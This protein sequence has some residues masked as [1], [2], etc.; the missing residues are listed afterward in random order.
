MLLRQ[1]F[2]ED[3]QPIGIDV[4]HPPASPP[5]PTPSR[6]SP[7]RSPPPD[8]SGFESIKLSSQPN[9]SLH[10]WASPAFLKRKAP[11]S[12]PY[13]GSL[14]DPFGD[15]S[16]YPEVSPTKRT[17]FSRKSAEWRFIERTPS[18]PLEFGSPLERQIEQQIEDEV[19][20]ANA[21][22]QEA[23][24]SPVSEPGLPMQERINEPVDRNQASPTLEL[25]PSH[26]GSVVEA[27]IATHSR[28]TLKTPE[29][30][31]ENRLSHDRDAELSPSTTP[32]TQVQEAASELTSNL[33]AHES[34]HDRVQNK[35][36]DVELY[37]RSEDSNPDF[38][39]TTS[40][41]SH[42]GDEALS[43]NIVDDDTVPYLEESLNPSGDKDPQEE[44]H[45]PLFS[46]ADASSMKH[47]DYSE[48]TTPSNQTLDEY[49]R[50]SIIGQDSLSLQTLEGVLRNSNGDPVIES[51]RDDQK[52]NRASPVSVIELSSSS[53]VQANPRFQSPSEGGSSQSE[54]M[55]DLDDY[56]DFDESVHSTNSEEEEADYPSDSMSE[57]EYED[58]SIEYDSGAEH[59]TSQAR[60][61]G[62]VYED[63]YFSKRSQYEEEDVSNPI[64][65]Q[66]LYT[67]SSGSEDNEIAQALPDMQDREEQRSDSQ[68]LD[69][70][71][72][73]IRSATSNSDVV[74]FDKPFEQVWRE[75][76]AGTNEP[77]N[78]PRGKAVSSAR[79][80]ESSRDVS[81]L[82]YETLPLSRP[83]TRLEVTQEFQKIK[84]PSPITESAEEQ[85]AHQEN[86]ANSEKYK[87]REAAF[88]G[89][90]LD[91]RIVDHNDARKSLQRSQPPTQVE[92][93]SPD[94]KSLQQMSPTSAAWA[95]LEQLQGSDTSK[96]S[97]TKSENGLRQLHQ[98]APDILPYAPDLAHEEGS[99]ATNKNLQ[100]PASLGDRPGRQQ[101]AGAN[102]ATSRPVRDSSMQEISLSE[103]LPSTDEAK[104]MG[105]NI[106][107]IEP[108]DADYWDE[109]D[110][111]IEE[112]DRSSLLDEAESD[113]GSDVMDYVE[114][115]DQQEADS[116]QPR[117]VRNKMFP[118]KSSIVEIIDLDTSD[119]EVPTTPKKPVVSQQF[120]EEIDN[121][122][123]GPNHD[124]EPV[125]EDQSDLL[126]SSDSESMNEQDTAGIQTSAEHDEMVGNR[127]YSPVSKTSK[128][129][130]NDT[131]SED[132]SFTE[133][134]TAEPHHS[135]DYEEPTLSQK[136]GSETPRPLTTVMH[137]TGTTP[138][139][140]IEEI[141]EQAV[142]TI[143]QIPESHNDGPMMES[144]NSYDSQY[145]DT[146][147]PIPL[148]E[149]DIELISTQS[150]GNRSKP[151]LDEISDSAAE[152]QPLDKVSEMKSEESFVKMPTS[153]HRDTSLQND[154]AEMEQDEISI[155][156]GNDSNEDY[157]QEYTLE[158]SRD[159]LEQRTQLPTPTA[160]QLTRTK[161]ESSESLLT[162]EAEN[163]TLPTPSLTQRTSEV[164]HTVVTQD[165]ELTPKIRSE[166]FSHDE[167][168]DSPDVSNVAPTAYP[169][170][171]PT[172]PGSLRKSSLVQRLKEMR[173]ESAK[174]HRFSP[175]NDTSS[176]ASPWFGPRRSS[177]LAEPTDQEPAD[178][179]HEDSDREG[180]IS[181]E[182]EGES[183]PQHQLALPRDRVSSLFAKP[184]LNRLP[185]SSPPP[186][187]VE[188]AAGFRTNLSY[189]AP[190]NTIRSHYNN[191]T[192]VLGLV[193][194]STAIERATTGPKDY[195]STIYITDPSSS[196]PPSVT[197]AR[198]FRPS[199]FS[200]PQ[201]QEGDAILFRN[202]R[203]VSFRRQ[204]GLLSTDSS[205]WAVFRRGEEPQISGPPV[206]FGAEER[207]FAR[208]LWDWWATVEQE[209]FVRAV[210]SDLTGS[211]QSP[212]RGRPKGS[213]NKASLVRHELRD[214]TTYVDNS[215]G[216]DDDSVHE[217]RDGTKWSD[218][219]L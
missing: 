42:T 185:S 215:K 97:F 23:L 35:L 121:C 219:K 194:T 117:N 181:S 119:E 176:A 180:D 38:Q 187:P 105:E 171:I 47:S 87:R 165:S 210:P 195:H 126:N 18:P 2:R 65:G 28:Q 14:Y 140:G 15:R 152:D 208:G 146:H 139:H 83:K 66:E 3:Q 109:A 206:E 51:A 205:A 99:A 211:N 43:R 141:E 34:D 154:N 92:S 192:S 21:E 188:I 218:S 200:F 54:E 100:Y 178:G 107:H 131:Y 127:T 128:R 41:L 145:P 138:D 182:V 5:T 29:E 80:T 12:T 91:S 6:S 106:A 136:E 74:I 31:G 103:H 132:P 40:I 45:N 153:S 111:A 96:L 118:I 13:P 135:L 32:Q 214:G 71:D 9:A 20:I 144:Q 10:T 46:D 59:V 101:N 120:R 69:G 61:T 110:D 122:S 216:A 150:S 125:K 70:I 50:Q 8:T 149:S 67:R 24:P 191:T 113:E 56:D 86:D 193:I 158:D 114:P 75:S 77:T 102:Y 36:V 116:Q 166:D 167:L 213:K 88:Q 108:E 186:Q 168:K 196:D 17:R 163:N 82:G 52:A 159:E 95:A 130:I 197:S 143:T 157:T 204:L 72:N 203:V 137:S 124:Q 155:Q 33:R 190:L 104:E 189:F 209:D 175:A 7:Q 53:Q 129:E 123:A 55:L 147:A 112:A 78:E 156:V 64:E 68:E 169:K 173:S 148:V 217:L 98:A 22:Q 62:I 16:D 142:L 57:R 93:E 201:V 151:R 177:R 4:D 90:V 160:T 63:D 179:L 60:S 183:H 133:S 39:K 164:V 30:V 48:Q 37:P 85:S 94:V 81:T 44:E 73:E 84:S 25:K 1:L 49:L 212:K 172:T 115:T 198:I 202:F 199:K 207:G 19:S 134:E 79:L 27:P 170:I 89:R 76:R 161:S 184:Q 58:R 162:Y 174:K 11:S 26:E